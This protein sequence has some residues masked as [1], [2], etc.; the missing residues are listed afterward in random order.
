MH[1]IGRPPSTLARVMD[2]QANG[3][4]NL[5]WD[6]LEQECEASSLMLIDRALCEPQ[7]TRAKE[8]LLKARVFLQ[9][10]RD[11]D[12]S[13]NRRNL[14]I[15]EEHRA[16]AGILDNTAGELDAEPKSAA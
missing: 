1:N 13:E 6:P 11:G 7:T 14:R 12:E 10:S 4:D 16:I 15:T 8:A 9:K 2:A 3:L 5:D